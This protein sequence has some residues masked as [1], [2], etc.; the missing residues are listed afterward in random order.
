MNGVDSL[1]KGTTQVTAV[2]SAGQNY[3]ANVHPGDLWY[4]PPGMVPIQ[5]TYKELFHDLVIY[6]GIPHS[7]QALDDDPEGS[8]F[9][10]VR[11][12]SPSS[13]FIGL[14]IF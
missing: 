11:N 13:R 9:L 12:Y 14:P 2:N 1:W 8:E 6:Q 10:L 5:S 4:F 7:L 3:I